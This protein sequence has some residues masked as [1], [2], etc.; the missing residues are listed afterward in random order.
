[1][2]FYF[3]Y[4][5]KVT[6]S[7]FIEIGK[8]RFDLSKLKAIKK[9]D[10]EKLNDKKLMAL[11]EVIAGNDGLA[12]TSEISL[13]ANKLK[14]SDGNNDNIIDKKEFKQFKKDNK[15]FLDNI[16]VDQES[17]AKL[18]DIS[19]SQPDETSEM[20]GKLSDL[21]G[22]D[23][24]LDEFFAALGHEK[25]EDEIQTET[26]DFIYSEYSNGLKLLEDYDPGLISKGYNAVKEFLKSDLSKSNVKKQ[27]YVKQET[28]ILLSKAKNG[29]LTKR[30]YYQS[31]KEVLFD[32]FPNLDSLSSERK[33]ELRTRIDTLSPSQVARNISD[34]LRLPNPDDKSYQSMLSTY[35][36][37]FASETSITQSVDTTAYEQ[38]IHSET[39]SIA[40]PY[41]LQGGEELMTFE[42][43]FEDRY[44][45]PYDSEKYE[46]LVDARN[47]LMMMSSSRASYNELYNLLHPAIVNGEGLQEPGHGQQSELIQSSAVYNLQNTIM[48]ALNK[49]GYTDDALKTEFMRKVLNSDSIEIKNGQFTS[50]V[51]SA[52]PFQYPKT[53]SL[54]NLTNI[55]R[56]LLSYVEKN[57]PTEDEITSQSAIVE[58]RY[59]EVFGN[60]DTDSLV[61]AFIQDSESVVST[62]RTGVEAAGV[63]AMVVG[64]FVCTPLAVGGAIAGGVGGIA[65][66]GVNEL[67]RKEISGEKMKEL[68]KELALNA[69]LFASGLGATKAGLAAKALLVAKNCPRL[70]A[71][72]AD[73]GVDVTLSAISNLILTGDLAL[74]QE[75]I[76]QIVSFIAGKYKAGRFGRG[77]ISR[78]DVNPFNNPMGNKALDNLAKTDPELYEDFKFLRNNNMLPSTTL[79]DVF[80][81]PKASLSEGMKSDIRTLAAAARNKV[82]PIDAFIPKYKTLEEAVS[83]RKLGET[84]CVGNSKNVYIMGNNGAVKLD[85]DRETYF[86]LFPP[87]VSAKSQQGNLG[88]CYLISGLI[89]ACMSNPQA[90]VELLKC[91]HQKGSDIVFDVG[92]YY[93]KLSDRLDSSINYE[94]YNALLDD[95]PQQI[96]FKNAKNR[97]SKLS[98]QT[99]SGAMGLKIAEQA[100]GYKIAA[101]TVALNMLKNHKSNAEIKEVMQE[102]AKIFENDAY[103]PSDKCLQVLK[104]VYKNT[105]MGKSLLDPKYPSNLKTS[106]LVSIDE[107]DALRTRFSGKGDSPVFVSVGLF[108]LSKSAYRTN[109]SL[110]ELVNGNYANNPNYIITASAVPGKNGLLDTLSALSGV[111]ER[112]K[113]TLSPGHAYRIAGIDNTNKMVSI[114]NPWD[115]SKIIKLTF[116]Q[117]QKYFGSHAAVVDI[118]KTVQS[119]RI[120]AL[121]EKVENSGLQSKAKNG[122]YY[123]NDEL[124]ELYF[125]S[126]KDVEFSK[127]T[128]VDFEDNLCSDIILQNKKV[129]AFEA[130]VRTKSDFNPCYKAQL[131]RGYEEGMLEPVVDAMSKFLDNYSVADN[132]K[133]QLMSIKKPAADYIFMLEQAPNVISRLLAKGYNESSIV[134]IVTRITKENFNSMKGLWS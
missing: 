50:N 127:P 117:Y 81:N 118:T 45:K 27:L 4:K 130:K 49:L 13:F 73:V 119:E 1:M 21:F 80:I 17:I 87:L 28:S 37:L 132:I 56:Q 101:K 97:S 32:I 36:E 131:D 134:N 10:I 53:D 39:K 103:K 59:R 52:S 124:I 78:Q 89:D 51:D 48:S 120:P 15:E 108:G 75:G 7:D 11:F 42:E 25:T 58:S 62:V 125:S 43:V 54:Y 47:K 90:K 94:N 61:N 63:A 111:G 71:C 64:M 60:K 129:A 57:A 18:F 107:F 93:A 2:P 34:I 106:I 104:D 88:D 102:L 100:M 109:L 95:M 68:G 41:N 133:V 116:E 30:E 74:E 114:V 105:S 8:N 40:Q 29:T 9:E 35:V 110:T 76:A 91:Y 72:I 67:G 79:A 55:A 22:E 113:Y 99:L 85:I 31:L 23:F 16:K 5:E 6:M 19:I 115:T 26:I 96:V 82:K 3:V 44:Q 38:R 14:A 86:S 70:V 20:T 83:M 12:D 98:G 33:E 46:Q 122:R 65:V 128:V 24:D 126:I 123:D 92:S 112:G 66:E 84:F 77:K 121:V 69:A